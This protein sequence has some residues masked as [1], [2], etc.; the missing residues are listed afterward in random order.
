MKIVFVALAFVC[1]SSAA[2]AEGKEAM[3]A[4]AQAIDAA[5]STDVA[6]AGCGSEKVGTGL[7]KCLHAYKKAHDDFKFSDGCHGAMEK[8]HADRKAKKK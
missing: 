8:A 7:M 6:T 5:C 1:F 2:F 4:D 3:G